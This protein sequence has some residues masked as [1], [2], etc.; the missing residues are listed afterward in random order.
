[1]YCCKWI[2]FVFGGAMGL[3]LSSFEY[4]NPSLVAENAIPVPLKQQLKDA[5]RDMG[6]RSYSM[7]KNFAYVGAIYATTECVIESVCK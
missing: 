1:M 6:R 5:A 2:G 7:A 4:S 3:F